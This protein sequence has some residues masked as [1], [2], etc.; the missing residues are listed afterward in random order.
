MQKVKTMNLPIVYTSLDGFRLD[1]AD[2]RHMFC[3]GDNSVEWIIETATVLL[4]NRTPSELRAKEE[5]QRLYPDVQEQVYFRIK[6]KSCFL[7]FFIPSHNIAIEIDGGY[8]L[9]RR[10]EDKKRDSLFDGI[11]IKTIRIR[12]D[13]VMGGF[14]K[15][16]FFRAG[17]KKK[18]KRKRKTKR[19]LAWE[20]F[21]RFR[22]LANRTKSAP[23]KNNSSHINLIN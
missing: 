4:E 23:I 22:V 16:D 10:Q 1:K 12:E 20:R 21:E 15:E 9:N 13:R 19:Q 11:G 18:H 2:V 17:K 3:L 14:L 5:L 7:D 8:H 6:G